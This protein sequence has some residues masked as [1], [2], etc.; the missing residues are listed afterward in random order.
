MQTREALYYLGC[1]GLVSNTCKDFIE[2]LGESGEMGGNPIHIDLSPIKNYKEMAW[3]YLREG[4]L[5]SF[6]Q[7]IEGYDEVV[8]M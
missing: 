4:R 7:Y 3:T 8:S 2:N 6:M 1:A 5:V